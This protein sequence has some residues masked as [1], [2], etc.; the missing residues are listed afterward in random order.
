MNYVPRETFTDNPVICARILDR[1]TF[2]SVIVQFHKMSQMSHHILHRENKILHLQS[3]KQNYYII[4]FW[5]IIKAIFTSLWHFQRGKWIMDYGILRLGSARM[6]RQNWNQSKTE[7]SKSWRLDKIGTS[8]KWT[9]LV[10]VPRRGV[11]RSLE[12]LK[13]DCICLDRNWA[14]SNPMHYVVPNKIDISYWFSDAIRCPFSILP[15]P[16]PDPYFSLTKFLGKG[17]FPNRFLI[18]GPAWGP[19]RAWQNAISAI[20]FAGFLEKNIYDNQSR[21][22]RNPNATGKQSFVLKVS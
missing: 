4:S 19:K 13:Y 6:S 18:G 2:F 22:K 8:Q 10:L 20:F 14:N 9:I 12:W 11:G 3:S 5:A 15:P 1:E 21:S 7:N 17:K 16:R